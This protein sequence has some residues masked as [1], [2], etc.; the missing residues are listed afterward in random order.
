[1]YFVLSM[2]RPASVQSTQACLCVRTRRPSVVPLCVHH[3]LL[4]ASSYAIASPHSRRLCRRRVLASRAAHSST[5]HPH[6]SPTPH[7]TSFT[8]PLCCLLTARSVHLSLVCRIQ[9]SALFGGCSAGRGRSSHRPPGRAAVSDWIV[10]HSCAKPCLA[11]EWN[12]PLT[13]SSIQKHS[14]TGMSV[15]R[16]TP[17]PACRASVYPSLPHQQGRAGMQ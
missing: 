16:A 14:S 5:S 12:A 3:P 15:C 9:H 6:R 17:C 10:Q 8:H 2:V 11:C 1:M 7:S 4:L 13:L